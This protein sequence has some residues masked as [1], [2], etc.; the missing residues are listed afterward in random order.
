[1]RAVCNPVPIGCVEILDFTFA[2]LD[3]LTVDVKL[4]ILIRLDRDMEAGD[5]SYIPVFLDSAPWV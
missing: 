4:D 1:M 2:H 5:A 3:A